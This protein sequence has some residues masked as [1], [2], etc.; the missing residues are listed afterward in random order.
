[1]TADISL[2]FCRRERRRGF[3]FVGQDATLRFDWNEGMLV[4]IGDDM[5]CQTLWSQREYDVNQMYEAMLDD[6][7][8]AIQQSGDAPVP[9]AAG[10]ATARVCA[11]VITR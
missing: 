8:I 9:L 7:L 5:P 11:A 2:S 6:F 1:V 10:L 4:R 3:E